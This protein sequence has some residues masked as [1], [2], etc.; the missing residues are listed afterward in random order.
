MSETI[1][2]ILFWSL[3]FTYV[4]FAVYYIFDFIW[5]S[6]ENKKK[7]G[8]MYTIRIIWIPV[9]AVVFFLVFFILLLSSLYYFGIIVAT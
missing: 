6:P 7:F 8:P 2:V 9:N 3:V 5:P 1:Q 4:I